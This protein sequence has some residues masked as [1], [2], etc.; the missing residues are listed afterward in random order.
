MSAS[1]DVNPP[2]SSRRPL[3][4]DQR[5]HLVLEGLSG[6]RQVTDL[7]REMGVSRERYY[8]M[9]RQAMTQLA[10]ALSPKKRGRKPKAPDPEKEE[11]RREIES[12]RK[13]KTH[14]DTLWRVAQ[15]AISYRVREDA[16]K[17][18]AMARRGTR[19]RPKR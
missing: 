1:Q 9:A 17:K 6:K 13:D 16:V 18:T 11:M 8:E 19:R 5:I 7:C 14:L 4:L 15:R 3:T 10:Q 2:P 12:L